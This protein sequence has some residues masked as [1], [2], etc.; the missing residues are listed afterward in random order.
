MSKCIHVHLLPDLIPPNA[1]TGQTAVII[2]VLRASS[3][4]VTALDQGAAAVIPCADPT[5][6]KRIKAA[7][8]TAT[9]PVLLGGERGGVRIDGFDL[10]NSPAEYTREMVA[11]RRIV[12]TT[13]NGTRALLRCRQA[14]QIVIGC[15]LNLAGLTDWLAG[16]APEV[17]LV[18]AGTD[19]I[20]SGEDVLAAGAFVQQLA[21]IQGTEPD[22]NDSAAIARGAA[23]QLLGPAVKNST[24]LAAYF[25]STQ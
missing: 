24:A 19:G 1:V 2:D 16:T 14:R 20:V 4:I 12:F 25:L 6:A 7:L 10:G 5:E 11:G 3:T 22:M 23:V 21:L 18:C 13:T 9:A 17:H 8:A 15:W